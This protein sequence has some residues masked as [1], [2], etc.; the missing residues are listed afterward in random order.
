MWTKPARRKRAISAL[1]IGEIKPSASFE[2]ASQRTPAACGMSSLVRKGTPVNGPLGRPADMAFSAS[3]GSVRQT[4]LICGLI[5]SI[6]A[7]A[8]SNSSRAVTCF[9]ATSSARPRPSWSV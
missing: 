3:P 4:A 6:A 8:V 5:R 9:V 2:P 7:T 1:S